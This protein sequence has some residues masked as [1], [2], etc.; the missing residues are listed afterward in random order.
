MKAYRMWKH[1]HCLL[2]WY[3]KV[4]SGEM[5]CYNTYHSQWIKL[6]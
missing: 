6:Y 1:N 5:F 4:R 2:L 3:I